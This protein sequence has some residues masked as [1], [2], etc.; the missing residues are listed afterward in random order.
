MRRQEKEAEKAALD[1]TPQV[2]HPRQ[3]TIKKGTHFDSDVDVKDVPEVPSRGSSWNISRPAGGRFLDHDPVF[4]LGEKYLFLATKRGVHV[5]STADSLLVRTLFANPNDTVTSYALSSTNPNHIYVAHSAGDIILWDWTSGGEVL[6]IP[7]KWAIRAVTIAKVHRTEYDTIFT[8]ESEKTKNGVRDHIVARHVLWKA[9]K[10]TEMSLYR[11][12]RDDPLLFL[13]VLDGGNVIFAA[14]AKELVVGSDGHHHGD[15]DDELDPI[16]FKERYTWREQPSTVDITCLDAEARPRHTDQDVKRS[17]KLG[18][19]KYNLVYGDAQGSTYIYEDILHKMEQRE[20]NKKLEKSLKPRVD[21][22]HREAVSTVKWSLDSNYVISGGKETVLVLLQLE[23]GKRQ[24]LP[25]LTSAILSLTVSPKGTSYAVHLAD[26]SVMVLSTSELQPKTNIPGIQSLFTS[27]TPSLL[28]QVPTITSL[29]QVS[30]DPVDAFGRTPAV[31]NPHNPNH[32]LLA[33]PASQDNS[34]DINSPAPAP[35]L[36]TFDAFTGR[37]VTRQALSRNLAITA[38]IGPDLTKLKEPNVTHIQ[39]SANGQWLSTVEEWTPPAADVDFTVYTKD[40]VVSEQKRRLETYLKFWRWDQ[41]SDQWVLE[42]RVDL[43]HQSPNNPV[44]N[45]VFDLVAH[46]RLTAFATTGQDGVVR[47]WTPKTRLGDGTVIRGAKGEGAI[48]WRCSH[49]IELENI[50]AVGDAGLDFPAVPAPTKAKLA[51]SND[52]SILVATQ[53]SSKAYEAGLVHFFDAATGT[54]K[55]SEPAMYLGGLIDIGFLGRYFIILSDDLRVWDVVT[56]K[57]IYGF[58]LRIPHKLT[59]MQKT[60]MSYLALNVS[61]NT[62]AIAV[63]KTNAGTADMLWGPEDLFSTV[64][65]FNPARPDPIISY[66]TA[67]PLTA[68]VSLTGT[69]GFV[70]LD[71][72][73]EY[74]ILSPKNSTMSLSSTVNGEPLQIEAVKEEEDIQMEEDDDDAVP[75]AER[76]DDEDMVDLMNDE[77]R[78]VR[79]EQ[80]AGIFDNGPSFALPP[81]HEIFKSVVGLYGKKATA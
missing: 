63:P 67:S 27:T 69:S 22:W 80:L 32:L 29:C 79:P 18:Q 78:V 23:T 58:K 30:D 46:P 71:A 65:I 54:L 38:N 37:H 9:A 57:L 2:E 74:R 11:W 50:P 42:T 3:I 81:V 75:G 5:Y 40:K 31:N 14:S 1:A 6:T 7:S 26:N 39:I 43:P 47:L 36:Q 12:K 52:G 45:R 13:K 24:N 60:A 16:K 73:A 55:Y 62:F 17:D 4:S 66:D 61:S 70:V 33:V 15:S 28:P 10:T 56:N 53:E 77:K 8:I 25:H 68:L 51:Y 21:R 49:S 72:S 44:A 19:M 59:P 64:T 48:S 35:F 20:Q 76:G 34:V 41:E